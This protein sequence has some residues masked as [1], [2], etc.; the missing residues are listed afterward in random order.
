MAGPASCRCRIPTI[1]STAE[2]REMHPL[3]ID[4]GVQT[5]LYSPLN[6]GRLARPWGVTTARAETEAAYKLGAATADSDKQIVDAVGAIAEER[7]VGRSMIALA[8]LR[9]NPVVA[10]PIVG[11][12]KA[13]HIDDA[14]ASLSISLTDDEAARLEAP[15]TPRLDHQGVSD[16][17]MLRR[18]A[19]AATGHS[20]SHLPVR[21]SLAN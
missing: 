15:Y 8:W 16:P 20:I 3:C 7:G 2:E 19:E 11:A 18:A 4:E 13:E 5:I 1:F 14:V 10:A 6:R 9:R 17:A 21:A 12:L